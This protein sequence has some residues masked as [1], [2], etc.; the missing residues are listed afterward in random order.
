MYIIGELK[1]FVKWLL[2]LVYITERMFKEKSYTEFKGKTK[3]IFYG[4]K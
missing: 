2:I 4:I 1:I 3:N